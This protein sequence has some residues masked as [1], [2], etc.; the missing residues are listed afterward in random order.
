MKKS[1]SV[2]T[3][4]GARGNPG[5]AAAAFIVK[6]EQ[7]KI[8]FSA[9]KKIGRATNNVAE[10]TAVIEALKWLAA[11][12]AKVRPHQ[13]P[14]NF[15]VDSKLIVSQLNGLFK[16]KNSNLRK[17]IIEIR[18]LEQIVGGNIFYYYIPREKNQESDFLVWKTFR[19]STP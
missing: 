7:G 10:Y 19:Q 4:G 15:F 11:N 9:G 1:I 13:Q 18:K 16:V 5:P 12:L 2:F 8:I 3:D 6:D 17:L 14:I